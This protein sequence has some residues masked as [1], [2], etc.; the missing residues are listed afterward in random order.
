MPLLDLTPPVAVPGSLATYTR[1]G[2]IVPELRERDTAGVISELSVVLQ[3]AG[4]VP[5]LLPF[6]HVALNQELLTSS[7]VENGIA[8]P[9]ARS[10][11]VKQLRFAFGRTREPIIWGARSAWQVQLVFLLAVP[12]TDAATYLHLLASIAKLSQQ[13][14]CLADLRAAQSPEQILAVL[15]RIEVRQR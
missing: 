7:A 8:L 1:A 9:H 6:Y 10:S 14:K 2:L 3:R 15:D 11:G 5:D 12:A 4:C 13:T